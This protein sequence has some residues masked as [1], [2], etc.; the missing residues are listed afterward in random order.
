MLKH[1]GTKLLSSVAEAMPE[2]I[3][4][5]IEVHS[6]RR[7]LVRIACSETGLTD[8]LIGAERG[9]ISLAEIQRS[10]A[11]DPAS[12]RLLLLLGC[13]FKLFQRDPKSLRY[14][15][16][17]KH[18]PDMPPLLYPLFDA[19]PS[20]LAESLK[21]CTN[22]GLRV[23][24]GSGA[25]LYERLGEYPE[26]E[27]Q[28]IADLAATNKAERVPVVL[29]GILRL[30]GQVHHVLDFGG[31]TGTTAAAITSH[32]PDI[33]VT[34]FD[35]PSVCAV[36]RRECKSES[37]TFT[38]GDIMVDPLPT[39]PD[40]VLLSAVLEVMPAK[41]AHQLMRKIYGILP[42]QGSVIII[43]PT[44]N[45]LETGPIGIACAAW[46]YFS[47]CAPAPMS[48]FTDDI[49]ALASSIGFSSF[50]IFQLK[51]RHPAA[52]ILKK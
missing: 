1:I 22:A 37:V 41:L 44:A 8:L 7:R 3:A 5:V 32:F 10:I 27:Q 31:S 30:K 45:M 15:R 49:R 35:L 2:K 34:V 20:F 14:Y 18:R 21:T 47:V 40:C 24:P 43:Q 42:T 11:L 51:G 4:A 19:S 52:M 23:L 25:T 39:G 36:G 50:E 13:A 38:E 48:I 33:R 6:R 9:G 16:T 46:F 29:K 28:Y 26:L 12:L 17:Q